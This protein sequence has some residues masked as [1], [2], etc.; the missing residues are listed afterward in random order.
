MIA[1]GA[2]T[3][4]GVGEEVSHVRGIKEKMMAQSWSSRLSGLSR[5]ED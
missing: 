1:D 4:A 2:L 3:I 5:V